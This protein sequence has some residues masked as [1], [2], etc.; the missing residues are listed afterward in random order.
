MKSIPTPYYLIDERKLLKNLK[1]IKRV[2]EKSG[3]KSVLALKCFS[4]WAVF[5]LM[6]QYMDGTTSS[7]VYEA[8]LG[9][10]KFGKEVHAY[11][12]G[13]SRDDVQQVA[14]FADKIIFNSL[15]QLKAFGRFAQGKSI[16][17]RVN[18][19]FSFSHFDLADPARKFSRLGI[20]DN[21]ELCEA[22]GLVKGVMFHFNCENDDI[23]NLSANIERIGR[24]YGWLITQMDWVSFGGGIFFTKPGYALE[25]FC[26]MLKRFSDTFN[27]QVYLEPGET[28]ITGAGEL[29]TTVLDVV[30][31]ETD[32]AIVDASTEAHMLDHLIYRTT[33]RIV[34]PSQGK[35]KTMIA[36]RSCL[37]GDVFGTFALRTRLRPGSI[38]RIGD[39]A[40]YTMVKKN[41]FNGM[42][43]PAIVVRRLNGRIEIVRRFSYHDFCAGLS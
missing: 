9:H 22:A 2:R 16:G 37:A 17:V 4:T 10:D 5:P 13:Y 24:T 18:P 40:G 32:I 36:G 1:I 15:S 42:P 11:S 12:V 3:A 20:R 30:R 8:R 7:G 25:K 26:D 39:A 6:R 19:G 14:R 34:S 23:K 28:A 21:R 33:A 31:N 29:V 27:V 35:F 38:V 41:W 43:M